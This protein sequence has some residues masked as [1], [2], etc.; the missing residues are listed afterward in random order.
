MNK[1]FVVEILKN[2]RFWKAGTI[3]TFKYQDWEL[4]LKKEEPIYKPFIFA[5]NGKKSNSNETISRRFISAEM[6]FLYIL[7]GFNENCNVK[8]KYQSLEDAFKVME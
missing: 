4:I 5:I 3:V 8:N 2:C 6:A 7:N 1:N